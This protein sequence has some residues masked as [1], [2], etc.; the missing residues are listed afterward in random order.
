MAGSYWA[1]SIGADLVKE[2]VPLVCGDHSGL[3]KLLSAVMLRA[4]AGLASSWTERATLKLWLLI[5][6]I[7]YTT[8]HHVVDWSHDPFVFLVKGWVLMVQ[9]LTRR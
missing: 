2:L 5:S 3:V 4:Y 1:P 9:P 7:I 6:I 8:A